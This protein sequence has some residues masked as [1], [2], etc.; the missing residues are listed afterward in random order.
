MSK[1][2]ICAYCQK[3]GKLTKEHIWPN[4]LIT[5]MP[6]LQVNYLKS[7]QLFTSSDLVIADVCA[8][9]NNKKLSP[10]DT[11]FCSLYDQYFNTYQEDT[12][13]FK[14]AYNYDLL[15]RSLL[16][17]TYNSSRTVAR[18]QNDFEKYREVILD[19]NL[20]RE[21]V[22]IKLD[23]IRPT[24]V[25]EKK[26]YPSS[27]RCGVIQLPAETPHFLLRFISVNSFYFYLILSKSP[28]IQ[29]DTFEEFGR[30][31]ESVPGTIIHPYKSEVVLG[32]FS[33]HDTE[34]IHIDF[35]SGTQELY[36]DYAAKKRRQ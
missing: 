35:L 24:I 18:D 17:I 16:K 36:H 20:I 23:L 26:V 6:E 10:L 30:V 27:A 31:F 12:T 3:P 34:S 29:P 8:T 25:N 21:D 19:G 2:R 4:C 28:T 13:P 15:L 33:G 22:V 7:R 11:Y 9:C 5:R 32:E 1:P 14:F